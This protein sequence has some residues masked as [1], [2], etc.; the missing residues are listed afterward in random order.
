MV[1]A[2]DSTAAEVAAAGGKAR[3]PIH[4]FFRPGTA[5]LAPGHELILGE[6]GSKAAGLGMFAGEQR[7]LVQTFYFLPFVVLVL[8]FGLSL[9]DSGHRAVGVELVVAGF[10][11]LCGH[12]VID[13]LQGIFAEDLVDF[14]GSAPMFELDDGRRE[15]GRKHLH[16]AVVVNAQ[17]NAG[18]QQDLDPAFAGA[19]FLASLH[20][21][22]ADI[23]LGKLLSV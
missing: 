13:D 5:Q 23:L 14:D 9:E 2:A 18:I 17:V 7:H 11:H 10:D 1:A 3:Q 12:A 16:G 22:R 15:V 4:R 6:I 8:D 21:D 19:Q 20:G